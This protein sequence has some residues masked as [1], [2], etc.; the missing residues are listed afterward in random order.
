MGRVSHTG[1]CARNGAA[2][3]CGAGQGRRA[4]APTANCLLAGSRLDGP[5]RAPAAF[6]ARWSFAAQPVSWERGSDLSRPAAS[7]QRTR[8]ARAGSPASTDRAIVLAPHLLSILGK[9]KEYI[10]ASVRGTKGRVSAGHA[11]V[12]PRQ[13]TKASAPANPFSR[14]RG[15]LRGFFLLRVGDGG[16]ARQPP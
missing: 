4:P 16:P 8:E 1:L 15:T 5:T 7:Q 6:A 13:T 9:L 12:A 10:T 2:W 3:G 14:A 11:E